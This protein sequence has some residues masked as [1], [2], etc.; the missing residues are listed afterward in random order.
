M[1]LYEA[2]RKGSRLFPTQAFGTYKSS[3]GRRCALGAAAEASGVFL[4]PFGIGAWN[5]QRPFPELEE[6]T[7]CPH[8]GK[9]MQI[10]TAIHHLNDYAKWSREAIAEWVDPHPELHEPVSQLAVQQLVEAG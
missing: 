4:L 1:T 6:L 8:C 3:G 5:L 10:I 9:R 7:M 2:I